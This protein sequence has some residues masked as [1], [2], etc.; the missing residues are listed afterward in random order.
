MISASKIAKE[1]VLSASTGQLTLFFDVFITLN[2]S[3]F[4]IHFK[5]AL[6]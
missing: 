3:V 5:G 6:N 4:L 1:S 2:N